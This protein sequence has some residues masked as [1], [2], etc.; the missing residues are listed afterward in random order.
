MANTMMDTLVP[1]PIP[2]PGG[3]L[4]CVENSLFAPCRKRARRGQ[5][6]SRLT[7]RSRALYALKD[8]KA[9]CTLKAEYDGG[10]RSVPIRQIRG[11]E[12]RSRYFDCD[13]NPLYDEA[14]G[15]WL[16]IA[17]ARQQGKNLPPVVLV[18][19]GDIY[20]VRDGHHRISVARALGQLYIE[21]R[22][23]VW[24]VIGPLPWDAPEQPSRPGLAGW[25][26]GMRHAFKRSVSIVD[27]V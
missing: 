17:R 9:A 16:N 4:F 8:V 27:E 20:F 11:S 26:L 7:G 13:F 18:Q 12:G 2:V 1:K 23:T 15:R 10:T 22:V 6:W 24:Q 21:A 5:F 3:S 19:V 25:L 14:R